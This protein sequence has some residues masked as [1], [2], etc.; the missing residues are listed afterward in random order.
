MYDAG[1]PINF[2]DDRW[3]D[4]N[5]LTGLLKMWMRELPEPIIQEKELRAFQS[6][7]GELWHQ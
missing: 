2:D 4:I 7:V 5:I 3:A 1:E 6:V